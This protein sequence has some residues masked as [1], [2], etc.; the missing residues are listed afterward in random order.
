[1]SFRERKSQKPNLTRGRILDLASHKHFN[2][3]IV[4]IGGFWGFFWAFRGLSTCS[5]DM[6]TRALQLFLKYFFDS[7]SDIIFHPYIWTTPCKV[8]SP[9]EIT[10]WGWWK[11]NPL[12]GR[13]R[14]AASQMFVYIWDLL[15][16]IGYLTQSCFQLTNLNISKHSSHNL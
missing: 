6:F 13:G 16:I 1:M 8:S 4:A 9:C 14:G 2:L 12:V 15:L 5:Y 3:I 10:A 7:K 11:L